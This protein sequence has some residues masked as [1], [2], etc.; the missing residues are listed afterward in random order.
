MTREIDFSKPLNADD[1]QYVQERPWL[2]Q[3][4]T[5]RGET[6]EYEDDDFVVDDSDN[7][8]NQNQGGNGLVTSGSLNPSAQVEDTSGDYAD[9]NVEELK[10]LLRERDLPVSG[11]KEQLI[12]RLVEDDNAPEDD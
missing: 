8:S 10:D 5:L 4:A 12:E 9:K 3:D 1:A 2:A 6:V 7:I 11:S